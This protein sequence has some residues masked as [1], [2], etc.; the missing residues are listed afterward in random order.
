MYLILRGHIRNSFDNNNLLDLIRG[1]VTICPELKI[2]IHTW[3]IFSNNISWRKISTDSRTVTP[4]IIQDYFQDL[5]H[6]I[7]HIIIDDDA[8]VKLLGNIDGNISR[9]NSPIKGWKYYWY[10]QHRI[11]KHLYDIE[12][13]KSCLVINTRFDLLNNSNS[14]RKNVVFDFIKNSKTNPSDK[15]MFIKKTAGPGIDNIYIGTLDNMYKLANHFH[16]NL[17]DIICKYKQVF[18][19]E[20]LVF[21]ESEIL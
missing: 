2:Y 11:A 1:I 4:S 15:N 6:L 5:R 18:H 19:P 8:N 7:Q 21:D 10:G 16:F 17:D 14:I 12:T 13:N 9:S 3:N 20:N